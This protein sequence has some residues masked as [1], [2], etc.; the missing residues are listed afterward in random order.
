MFSRVSNFG[1]R[2]DVRFLPRGPGRIATSKIG[3]STVR[4][5]IP[6]MLGVW[7]GGSLGAGAYVLWYRPVV[8]A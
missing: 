2:L 7:D 8:L 1:D 6:H 4:R 5:W 3:A